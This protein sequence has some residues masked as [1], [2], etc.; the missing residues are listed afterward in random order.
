LRRAQR[1]ADVLLRGGARACI[2]ENLGD[3]PFAAGA[4]E[5]HAVAHMAV[6]AAALR[7]Q[8]GSELLLGVNVLR[9]APLDALAVASAAGADFIRVNVHSGVMVT[10]QGIIQGQAR[11]TLL[12]RQRLQLACAVA[13]DVFVKHASPLGDMALEQV[14]HDSFH[15]AGA[16]ALVVSGS[17][18][19]QPADPARLD[20]VRSAVPEAAIWLGSGL[21]PDNADLYRGRCDAAIVGTD[22]HRDRDLAAPLELERVRRVVGAFSG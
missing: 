22:L 1:D 10:D 4:A 7:A 6:I 21:T 8:L 16:D 13:A 14:A 11:R 15:R 9:N 20:A 17:G 18:T 3:A 2:V 12:Y 19:G 5:P